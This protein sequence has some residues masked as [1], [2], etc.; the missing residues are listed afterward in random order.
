MRSVSN[1]QLIL[2]SVSHK[3]GLHTDSFTYQ[4]IFLSLVVPDETNARFLPAILIEDDDANLFVRRKMTKNQLVDKYDAED[5]VIIGKCCMVNCLKYGSNDWKK[6]NK[7]IES[8]IELG[9]NISVSE[10]IQAPTVYPISNNKFQVLTGHRRYFALVYANGYGSA[11]QFKRYESKPLLSKIKQFQENASRDEL[12]QYGKLQA[13]ESALMEIEQLNV[14]RIQCGHKKLTVKETATNLGISMGA[15]DNYNV[16]TRYR[17]IIDAYESG[18]S[19]SFVRVKKTV[20]AVELQYK[21]QH[22]KTVLNINDKRNIN[23][24]IKAT[25]YDKK[26]VKAVKTEFKLKPLS[27]FNAI[28]NLL[29]QDVTTLDTGIEWDTIDWNDHRSVANVLSTVMTFLEDESIRSKA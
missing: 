16:L 27:G 15:F 3:D 10:L 24:Q 29:T 28:K 1:S 17:C 5:H 23:D 12:P 21:Q 6:A 19:T 9:N 26:A 7:T 8:L 13:F 18:L 20:L 25:L 4:S 22:A 2:S 14:A 11:A